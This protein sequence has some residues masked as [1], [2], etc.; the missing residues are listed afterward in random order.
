MGAKHGQIA[1]LIAPAFLLLIRTVVLFVD[2]NDARTRHRGKQGRASADDDG[3]L[4]SA[5]T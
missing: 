1:S 5:R 4:S 2:N 3:I